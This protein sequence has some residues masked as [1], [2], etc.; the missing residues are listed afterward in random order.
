[1]TSI[2][3]DLDSYT[4]SSDPTEAVDYLL[5]NKNVIF[6]INAKNPYFEEIKT[7]YRINITR[8]EGDTIYFTIHSD[9]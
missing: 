7:R 1:M 2:M 9:G 6:K 5:L 8:Q 4:C 3:I